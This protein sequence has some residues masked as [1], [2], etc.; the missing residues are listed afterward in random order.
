[1]IF[2]VGDVVKANCTV[3]NKRIKNAIGVI[4]SIS[5]DMF[6][7]EFNENIDGHDGDGLG[8]GGYCWWLY[9]YELELYDNY[10][11][12]GNLKKEAAPVND[13]S[14]ACWHCMPG[15]IVDRLA[16]A[17]GAVLVCPVCGRVCDGRSVT[18]L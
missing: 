8:K 1:M 15:G 6:L 9:D 16:F 7:I 2:S 18:E 13:Y 12:G 14:R 5:Y 4:L 10:F 17:S 11:P 3:G